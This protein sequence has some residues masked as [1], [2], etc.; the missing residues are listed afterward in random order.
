MA[1]KT[2]AVEKVVAS[3]EIAISDDE[4][5]SL[6]AN[7]EWGQKQDPKQLLINLKAGRNLTHQ[8]IGSLL[9][10][11]GMSRLAD[12]TEAMKSAQAIAGDGS[13]A[14]DETKVKALG[15]VALAG[16]GYSSLLERIFKISQDVGEKRK[17]PEKKPE[18]PKFYMQ[19]NLGKTDEK[20]ANSGKV[21]EVKTVEPK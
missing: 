20:S 17:L 7:T 1:A 5:M 4:L 11:D 13:I 18:A 21:V 19:V 9:L 3:S 10:V 14:E 16:N 6:V 2:Q 15:A 12:F 8:V